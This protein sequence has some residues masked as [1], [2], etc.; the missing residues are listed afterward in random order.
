[1]RNQFQG[2]MED[3]LNGTVIPVSI[4]VIGW[5]HV[6]LKIE[7]IVDRVNMSKEYEIKG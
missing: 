2:S 1:M 6:H 7:G 5:N 4:S 3:K